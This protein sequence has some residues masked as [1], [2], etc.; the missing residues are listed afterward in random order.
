MVV[1]VVSPQYTRVVVVAAAV[2]KINKKNVDEEANGIGNLA[3]THQISA[4]SQS[5]LHYRRYIYVEVS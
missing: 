2:D 5:L 4:R 3:R 1:V